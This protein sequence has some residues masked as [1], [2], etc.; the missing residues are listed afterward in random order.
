MPKEPSEPDQL[1]GYR[2]TLRQVRGALQLLDDYLR[3]VS[4]D[5]HGNDWVKE[6]NLLAQVD[7][8]REAIAK[9]IESLQSIESLQLK[10]KS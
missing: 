10:P 9:A 3:Y 4:A 8:A 6:G 5:Y 7:A 1:E 2:A